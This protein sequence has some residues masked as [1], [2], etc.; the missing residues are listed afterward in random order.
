MIHLR[1]ISALFATAV[2]VTPSM[3]A[4]Q[5]KLVVAMPTNPP[6]IVHMPLYVAIDLGLFKKHGVT[7]EAV[8]LEGGVHAFRAMVAGNADVAS[9]PGPYSIVARSKGSGTKL[10]LANA[11]K[12]EVSM[13]VQNTIK[14]LA[15]LKGKRIGIQEPNGF[16]DVLSRSVLRA[17]KIDPKEVTFVS[18]LSEDVPPLVA[19]QID[20][21]IL[22]IEQEIIAK[23]KLPTLHAVARLWELQPKNL[24]N[25]MAVT[26]KTLASKRAA[27]VGFV[28]GHIEATRLM[29]TDKAKVMPVIV[30]YTNLPQ[31]VAEKSLDFL[32]KE[33]I[34]DANHGM[35]PSRVSW[36]TELM[37]RVGNIEKGKAP[38]YDEVIDISLAQE[39][40]KALG[41][42]KGPMCPSEQ[43]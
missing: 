13:V 3:V 5:Q 28:K 26:E 30:K 14:T 32:V 23:S 42:W 19:G 18:I 40:L 15:D 6:N 1:C 10:I 36:T 16:A 17:A 21:A 33:C 35:S 11:N 29:Y 31:D 34:W 22:H 12:L 37:E 9:S 7:V 4:A 25:V 38:K 24:Y 2:I 8:R 27:L 41:E 39:A 43:S 20:T